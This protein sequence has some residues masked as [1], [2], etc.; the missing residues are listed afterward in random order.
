MFD[1]DT[2]RK[3]LCST[4]VLF[5]AGRILLHPTDKKTNHQMIV[6]FSFQHHF[7]FFWSTFNTVQC[8]KWEKPTINVLNIQ[9]N[10]VEEI[11]HWPT[12]GLLQTVISLCCSVFICQQIMQWRINNNS[13]SRNLCF[14]VFFHQW[15]ECAKRPARHNQMQIHAQTLYCSGFKDKSLVWKTKPASLKLKVQFCNSVCKCKTT[16]STST[17]ETRDQYGDIETEKS[18]SQSQIKCN[19]SHTPGRWTK[20]ARPHLTFTQD[21]TEHWEH[22]FCKTFQY[23]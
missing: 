3:S 19:I 7:T 9:Y 22:Q 21:L 1:V 8:L 13:F 4:S 23:E 12:D 15:Q 5:S 6:I 10:L 18:M 2:S 11:Q 14:R 17:T 16:Q 20:T